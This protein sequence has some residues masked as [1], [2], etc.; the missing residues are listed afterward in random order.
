MFKGF[1]HTH[2][3]LRHEINPDGQRVEKNTPQEKA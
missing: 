1:K 3:Q 2:T